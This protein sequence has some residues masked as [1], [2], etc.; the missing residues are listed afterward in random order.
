[1]AKSDCI[2]VRAAGP[3]LDQLRAEASAIAKSSKVDWWVE[4]T[5]KGTCFY[6]EDAS[7]KKQFTAFCEKIDVPHLDG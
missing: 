4:R 3:Q 7:S 1:M 6:F 2:I 5:E